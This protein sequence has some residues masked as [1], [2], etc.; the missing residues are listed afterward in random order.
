[1]S[2]GTSLGRKEDARHKDLGLDI[3]DILLNISIIIISGFRT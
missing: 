1:M 2:E 3:S